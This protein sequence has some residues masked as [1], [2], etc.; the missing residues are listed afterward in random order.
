MDRARA[1][2]IASIRMRSRFVGNV[3]WWRGFLENVIN[4]WADFIDFYAIVVDNEGV[5]C[6]DINPTAA[7]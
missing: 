2:V 5:G 4:S 7:N 6:V 3:Q 1:S